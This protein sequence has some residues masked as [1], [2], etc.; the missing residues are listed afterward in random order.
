MG[1]NEDNIFD[2]DTSQDLKETPSKQLTASNFEEILN[3]NRV[4][5]AFLLLGLILFG[6]GFF[7]IRTQ[8][9][10][11]DKEVV[12]LDEDTNDEEST[13]LII[14][15]IA[16]AIEKPGVYEF[17]E[18]DRVEDLLIKSGGLSEDADQEWVERFINRAAILSDGLKVYI[19][20]LNKQTEGLTANQE[21][22][23]QTDTSVLGSEGST[24]VNINTATQS[25]L[26]EL[27]GIGPVYAQKII[28]QRP[29]SS[30]EE[31]L[32]KSVVKSN[33]YERNRDM[34]T[35]H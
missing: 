32:E 31:L 20:K 34:M 28:E 1:G 25:E 18:G 12:M 2:D 16:G 35:V 15:E 19:P 4:P 27:W 9:V 22:L 21:G 24:I 7:Y 5:I 30:I 14:V 11:T 23:Y 17:G 8:N 3:K 29:Y 6:V 26:E 13:K 10:A 33:V